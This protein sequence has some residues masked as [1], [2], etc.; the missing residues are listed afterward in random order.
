[1]LL[2]GF[3]YLDYKVFQKIVFPQ[4]YSRVFSVSIRSNFCTSLSLS[5]KKCGLEIAACI[6]I[7]HPMWQSPFCLYGCIFNLAI[8]VQVCNASYDTAGYGSDFILTL[9]I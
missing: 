9:P 8:R 1:M 4:S 7:A 3:V 5:P 2:N 6:G